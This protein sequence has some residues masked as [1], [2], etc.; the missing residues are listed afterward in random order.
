MCEWI[1]TNLEE[2][3]HVDVWSQLKRSRKDDVFLK[4]GTCNCPLYG[5]LLLHDS[6]VRSRYETIAAMASG[7]EAEFAGEEFCSVV[8]DFISAVSPES[9][10]R[11]D[12]MFLCMSLLNREAFG[13]TYL[14]TSWA[15]TDKFPLDPDIVK[16]STRCWVWDTFTI[17]CCIILIMHSLK[18]WKYFSFLNYAVSATP[19]VVGAWNTYFRRF[20]IDELSFTLAI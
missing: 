9:N 16:S 1:K 6:P 5:I 4:N 19:W 14:H 2:H 15:S 8:G 11:R 3:H 10:L 18:A 12:R 17:D 13:R 7:R 20:F